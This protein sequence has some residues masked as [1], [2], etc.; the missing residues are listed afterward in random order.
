MIVSKINRL[1]DAVFSSRKQLGVPPDSLEVHTM[2]NILNCPDVLTVEG[3]AQVLNV[4]RTTMYRLIKAGEIKH[5]NIGRKILIP[6]RYLQ[7]FIE[8][9]AE[10]CYNMN[11][12][13]AGNP[14]CRKKGV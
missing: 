14:P 13:E 4:G 2:T 1:V 3:A 7:D 9:Q 10:M 5:L 8:F 12:P 11:I 6:R